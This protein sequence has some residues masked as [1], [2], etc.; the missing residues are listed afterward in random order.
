M[1][2][3]QAIPTLPRKLS[4]EKVEEQTQDAQTQPRKK[5]HRLQSLL[6]DVKKCNQMSTKAVNSIKTSEQK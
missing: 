5:N 1:T 3:S 2:Q 4:P 6:R